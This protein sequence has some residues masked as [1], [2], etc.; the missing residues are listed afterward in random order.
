M[1][2]IVLKKSS[3]VLQGV[4]LSLYFIDWLAIRSSAKSNFLSPYQQVILVLTDFLECWWFDPVWKIQVCKAIPLKWL[5]WLHF[6]C[7]STRHLSQGKKESLWNWPNRK[8]YV[9]PRWRVFFKK[10]C[11]VIIFS[12]FKP[13][14]R[15][16]SLIYLMK[17][18]TGSL[19][20]QEEQSCETE[21]TR[22]SAL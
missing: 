17:T 20:S 3:L 8:G 5:L 12:C 11:L 15:S 7:G 6:N 21:Q 9:V 22:E 13:G 4:R 2:W 18:E 1:R 19:E 16:N 10:L 14:D